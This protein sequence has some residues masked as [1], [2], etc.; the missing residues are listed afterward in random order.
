M[1]CCYGLVKTNVEDL[2]YMLHGKMQVLGAETKKLTGSVPVVVLG[3]RRLGSIKH[4]LHESRVLV[5]D[6]KV[7]MAHL[8]LPI[9][10]EHEYLTP[11]KLK[12]LLQTDTGEIQFKR[13]RDPIKAA[14]K[15]NAA[16]S[17]LHLFLNIKYK[18]KDTEL[19]AKFSKAFLR[20]IEGDYGD[21]LRLAPVSCKPL[22]Q[23]LESDHGRNLRAALAELRQGAQV[24]LV[25]IN[26]GVPA[27]DLRYLMNKLNV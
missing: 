18:A 13:V 21:L 24:E 8:T 10:D 26:Y 22:L 25:A 23:Y 2:F 1:R 5:L 3:T 4:L 7:R 17:I 20:A 14:L 27:F 11:K 19:Q 15:A 6:T 12:R 9:A 16:A